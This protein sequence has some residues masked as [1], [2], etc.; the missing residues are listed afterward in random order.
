[1]KKE[2]IADSRIN[3]VS[4]LVLKA[5]QDILGDKLEK[6]ILYGSYARGDFDSESDIDFLI[7]ADVSQ[8]EASM[9][10]GEI[11]RLLP[12]IDLKYDLPVSLHVTGSTVFNQ[13]SSTLPFYMNVIREGVVLGE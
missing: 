11:R 8:E 10:R 13:Y 5:A 6:V 3:A 9:R 7:L 4:Q 12:G 2:D 1:M